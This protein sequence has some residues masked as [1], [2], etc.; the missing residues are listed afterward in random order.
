MAVYVPARVT[1]RAAP[2]APVVSGAVRTF[3]RTRHRANRSPCRSTTSAPAGTGRVVVFRN[4]VP[5]MRTFL[6]AVAA[7]G[8]A[9]V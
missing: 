7:S 9:V 6:R 1:I 3:P 2:S 5:M 4:T 8:S